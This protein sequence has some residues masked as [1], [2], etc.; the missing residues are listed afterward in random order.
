MSHSTLVAGALV[1]ALAAV[2]LAVAAETSADTHDASFAGQT[3]PGWEMSRGWVFG[4][5]GAKAEE[6]ATAVWQG[7]FS[8]TCWFEVTLDLP[9][10]EALAK[11]ASLAI[12]VGPSGNDRA[13]WSVRGSSQNPSATSH[14]PELE[15][16]PSRC[17]PAPFVT[18]A[19]RCCANSTKWTPTPAGRSIR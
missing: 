5:V 19:P 7:H 15:P 6:Q 13:G 9:S 18:H 1:L 16:I 3:P 10:A 14:L 8:E 17:R 2:S 4:A 11:G 12:S